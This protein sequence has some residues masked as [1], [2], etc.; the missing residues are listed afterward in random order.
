MTPSLIRPT[1]LLSATLVLV[2]AAGLAVSAQRGGATPMTVDFIAVGADGQPIADL[3]AG[4]ISLKVGGKD[5]PVTSLELVRFTAPAT[6]LPPPF[7]TNGATDAGRTVLFVVDEESMR[8][9]LENTVRES[10]TAFVKTLSPLDRVGV[11]ALPRGTA[12]LPPTTDRAQF[13]TAIG[14]LQGRAKASMT[15]EE[16]LCHGRDVLLALTAV[17]GNLAGQSTPTPVIFFSAALAPPSSGPATL[18]SSVDCQLSATEFQ[19]VSVAADAARAQ[20]FIV[21]AEEARTAG[22][23]EG[24]EN[25]AT[26]T[27]SPIMP[28]GTAADGAMTKIGKSTAGYYMATFAVEAPERNGGSH[29]LELKTTK[30][31]VTLHTRPGLHIPK[32]GAGAPT[33]QNMLRSPDTH[34]GFG[35]RF[36][37]VSSR[38]E[39]D[40]KN[41]VKL[42]GLAE[43]IDP[44]VKLSAAAAGVYDLAGK[45]VAQWTARPEE[46]QRSPMAAALAIPTG[47]FRVRIAAV[48]TQ[49]RAATVDYDLDTQMTPVGDAFMGGLLVGT[50]GQGFMPQLK[51]SNEAEAIVYFELYGRPAGRFGAVV[52]IAATIDGPALVEAPLTAAATSV[53]DMFRFTAKVPIAGLKPGDYFVRAKLAFEGQP[54]GM[55]TRTIRKQ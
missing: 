34:R 42:V 51:Y 55:L 22:L 29:R 5:R 48:D 24:L 37:V 14:A 47:K 31:G 10:M 4:E 54:T 32:G 44:T 41:N 52:E 7:A 49:G 26:I 30:A 2:T 53:A 23:V 27:G 18:G 35:M 11:F 1:L 21:K 43:P 45:L 9:G 39:A 50:A 28:I 16:R 19:R 38:N 20:M 17:L 15:S 33:P 12:T 25:L 36:L 8:A 46:L 13:Q 3:T 6:A 40:A